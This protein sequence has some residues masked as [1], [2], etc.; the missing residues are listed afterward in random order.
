MLLGCELV[1]WIEGNTLRDKL[2]LQ[3]RRWIGETAIQ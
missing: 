1:S 3:Q 2:L